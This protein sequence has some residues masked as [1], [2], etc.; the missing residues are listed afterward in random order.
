MEGNVDKR[1]LIKMKLDELVKPIENVN[2][3]V[4]FAFE[5]RICLKEW[6]KEHHTSD[7]GSINRKD[8]AWNLIDNLQE[9]IKFAVNSNAS[10]IS[11]SSMLAFNCELCDL[12]RKYYGDVK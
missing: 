4:D 12:I 10:D 8:P 2:D 6:L 9:G 7:R 1:K 3:A 11:L 5:L